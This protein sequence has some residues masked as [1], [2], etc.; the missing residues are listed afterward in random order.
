MIR[1]TL[2][3]SLLDFFFPNRCPVCMKLIGK[4]A[5]LC[6][7]CQAE[8]LLDSDKFCTGCGK[9]PCIC[10]KCRPIYDTAA[11]ACIYP[12]HGTSQAVI[13]LKQGT[14]I[15]FAFFAAGVLAEK[16]KNTEIYGNFDCIMPV[17]M[18]WIKQH[19]RGYNQA[20]LIGRELSRLLDVPYREDVLYKQ[21]ASEQHHL[22]AKERAM[23]TAC[24]GIRDKR[25]DGMRIVLCDDVLTTGSTMN[26]CAQLLKQKGAA[27]VIAAAAA[28]TKA[29]ET[30]S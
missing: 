6:P 24:F 21:R 13:R 7:E 1:N 9:I 18:H 29:P 25:V 10:Q 4:N 2:T 14:N 20:A 28:S 12:S 27:A 3:N 23:N 15:N 30:T 11:A 26:R 17:P 16:L 22:T 8:I 5:L 19:R